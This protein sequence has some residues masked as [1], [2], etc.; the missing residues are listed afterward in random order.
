MGTLAVVTVLVQPDPPMAFED[1][2]QSQADEIEFLFASV[3]EVAD[4]LAFAAHTETELARNGGESLVPRDPAF[5]RA[6]AA[7]CRR[8]DAG[9]VTPA[10][11]A[12]W[13]LIE[14]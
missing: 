14:E 11:A 7:E 4:Y 2:V 8:R 12:R 1:R 10:N 9:I 6:V 13:R 5:W 3:G